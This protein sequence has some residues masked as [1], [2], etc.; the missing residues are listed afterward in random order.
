MNPPQ[1]AFDGMR[2]RAEA[3]AVWTLR[4]EEA[5]RRRLRQRVNEYWDAL[6]CRQARKFSDGASPGS[7]GAEW[8]GKSGP[9][10]S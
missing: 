5:H 1:I 4:Q 10:V 7:G 8:A 3:Y 6:Q 2:L 9:T